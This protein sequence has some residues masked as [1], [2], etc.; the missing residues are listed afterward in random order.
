MKSIILYYSRSGNTEKVAQQIQ[1]DLDCDILKI[2]SEEQ[3]GNYAAS[4]L[5]IVKERSKKVVPAF[6][7]EIPDLKSY[8]FIFVGYPIW[9]Q[10]LPAFVSEFVSRC[11]LKGKTVIP[12]ATYG[13]SGIVW[14]RKTLEKVCSGAAIEL[15]YDI[16]VFKKGDYKKWID[17]VKQLISKNDSAAHL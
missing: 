1:R 4:C 17:S 11:D 2:V 16:G 9:A 8:D 3:Y 14:T 7:T 6:V 5:R 10:D 15:P 12:F 13:M